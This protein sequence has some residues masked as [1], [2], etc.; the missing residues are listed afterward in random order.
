MPRVFHARPY[1]AG[2]RVLHG[3]DA[4]LVRCRPA[5]S[6]RPLRA[7]QRRGPRAVV[8]DG[9]RPRSAPGRRPSPGRRLPPAHGPL[10]ASEGRPPPLRRARRGLRGKLGR[11]GC[12]STWRR[13]ATARSPPWQ[14]EGL[15]QLATS[16]RATGRPCA[17]PPGRPSSGAALGSR[18]APGG[19]VLPR[20][21]NGAARPSSCGVRG[22]QIISARVLGTR[23]RPVGDEPRVCAVEQLLN[24]ANRVSEELARSLATPSTRSPPW[25]SSP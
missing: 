7:L 1:G 6:L 12:S 24:G 19:P 23:R 5:R 16:W 25:W 14:E 20:R 9:G 2:R 10:G 18:D 3:G 8:A 4:P 22:R 11:A 21:D 15:M 13:S 17:A